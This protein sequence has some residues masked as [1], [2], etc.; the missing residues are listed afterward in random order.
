MESAHVSPYSLANNIL[1][2]SF[3]DKIPVNPMKLQR[4]IYYTC[5]IYLQK[6]GRPL[7]LEPFQV[8]Q[9]GPVL[10]SLYYKLKPYG[11][12]PV[13]EFVRDAKGQ[14]LVVNSPYIDACC[15][16]VWYF[17]KDVPATQLAERSCGDGSA[18][19]TAFKR[20]DKVIDL[21]DIKVD[22]TVP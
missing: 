5:A 2:F 7:L 3:K 14:A 13:T 22:K 1:A 11:K 15:A 6:I 19:N 21:E 10:A 4:M 18:W 16:F 12:K 8:W 17:F 20:N 9:Y